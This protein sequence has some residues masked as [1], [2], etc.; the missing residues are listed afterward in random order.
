MAATGVRRELLQALFPKWPARKNAEPP[1]SSS[2]GENIDISSHT[3]DLD[4]LGSRA[5]V[6]KL[7]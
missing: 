5:L 1:S 7:L 6:V 4:L 3:T 2:E